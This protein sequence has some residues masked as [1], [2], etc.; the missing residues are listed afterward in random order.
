MRKV[1]IKSLPYAQGGDSPQ[2][3]TI[4]T[5]RYIKPAPRDKSSLEAEKGEV[6]IT[7][8][9]KDGITESFL[10]GGQR[11]SNGGT[12]LSLPD[13]SFIFSRDKKLKIKDEGILTE[14][15]KKPLKKGYTPADLA[16]KYDLAK[17]RRVFSDPDSDDIQRNTAKIMI[18]NYNMKLAKLALAQESMKGFPQD[19]PAIALPYL[20]VNNIDPSELISGKKRPQAGQGNMYQQGGESMITPLTPMETEEAPISINPFHTQIYVPNQSATTSKQTYTKSALPEGAVVKD[21][22]SSDLKTGD[23]I[24]TP[25][26]KYRKVVG[27]KTNLTGSRSGPEGYHEFYGSNVEDDVK[28]ANS[29]LER[30]S[31]KPGSGI[32]YNKRTGKYDITGAAKKNLPLSDQVLLTRVSSYNEA[33]A[34]GKTLGASKY[35]FKVGSQNYQGTKLGFVG[36]VTPELV[37]YQYWSANNPGKDVKEF[38]SLPQEQKLDN[39]R[40]YLSYLG[41]DPNSRELVDKIDKPE[42]LYTP[43]FV[44]SSKERR[45]GTLVDRVQ[46]TFPKE[47]FR[48]IHEDDYVFGTEHADFYKFSKQAEFQDVKESPAD[49]VWICQ[50]GNVS[51][52]PK[53]QASGT[54]YMSKA[55]AI[56]ACQGPIAAQKA[57]PPSEWWAQDII[58]SAGAFSDLNRVKKYT[59]WAAPFE[60]ELGEPTFYDPTRELAAN[61][62]QTNIGAQAASTFAG[63]QSFNARF[64]QMQGQSAKNA[65]DIMARYNNL[66]V[67]VANQFAMQN[68]MSMSEANKINRDISQD[69]YDKM[70]IA[71]QQFDNA[72]AMARQ[73]LRQ[74][75]IDA[76]TNRANAQVLNTLYPQYNIS[77]ITGGMM[78]FTKGR[79]LAPTTPQQKDVM[80]LASDYMRTNPGF[81][82]Q[83]YFD[84]A[85]LAAGVQT[86]GYGYMPDPNFLQS[87]QNT[88]PGE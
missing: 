43:Q 20:A 47:M 58:K 86:P 67:G 74:S 22:S 26:G 62:E 9:N 42:D 11:H 75:Y 23:Y 65:A 63:P 61:A 87:Y 1:R 28:K 10:V 54:S 83:Q 51:S 80:Q 73:N 81:Q 37:E 59:P 45:E 19:I 56:A 29:V 68:A 84:A 25:E 34:E 7:D 66:N 14:F 30:L 5:R 12:P 44:G 38:E 76:V 78:R 24:K 85:K 60:P 46:K 36:W 17:Y 77:P 4:S 57:A 70:T 41:Y 31:E 64:K 6:V 21:Y 39:R 8:I 53:S 72:K 35:G 52:I 79:P 69:Q 40:K 48:P 88:I 3:D 49:M 71:N 15:G 32:T 2:D 50:D 16:K 33:T 27:F 13:N 55:A 82:P 18:E